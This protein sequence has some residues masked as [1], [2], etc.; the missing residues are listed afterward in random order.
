M[1]LAI[2]NQEESKKGAVETYGKFIPMLIDLPEP[3]VGSDYRS[4]FLMVSLISPKGG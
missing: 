1:S 2:E 3:I 4:C